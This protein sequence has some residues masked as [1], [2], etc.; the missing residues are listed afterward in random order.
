MTDV[1]VS[2]CVSMVHPVSDDGPRPT[3]NHAGPADHPVGVAVPTSTPTTNN[4][5][6]SSSTNQGHP[7]RQQKSVSH[8]G[9]IREEVQ[10][11]KDHRIHR[12]SPLG[13]PK[14]GQTARVQRMVQRAQREFEKIEQQPPYHSKHARPAI[15]TPEAY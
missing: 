12:Y 6:E 7:S 11:P 3:E 15:P 5:V 14:P 9:P 13:V 2:E 1:T 10:R 4:K 8:G